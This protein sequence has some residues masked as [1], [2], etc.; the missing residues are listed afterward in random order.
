[1]KPKPVNRLIKKRNGEYCQMLTKRIGQPSQEAK[2]QA[3]PK[4]RI[5]NNIITKLEIK[6]ANNPNKA[7][8]YKE[9]GRNREFKV[10]DNNKR[11]KRTK[12]NKEVKL[13]TESGA[14]SIIK[15][16][17]MPRIN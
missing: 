14:T 10:K 4:E 15:K 11:S 9:K 3:Q 2:R 5:S 1:M 6:L 16:A 17:R 7:K 12:E 8:E 13:T